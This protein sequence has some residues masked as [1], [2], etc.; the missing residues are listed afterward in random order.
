MQTF[1]KSLLNP[2]MQ[3]IQMAVNGNEI[4]SDNAIVALKALK[5]LLQIIYRTYNQ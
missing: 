4:L 2:I 1:N 3:S 5:P